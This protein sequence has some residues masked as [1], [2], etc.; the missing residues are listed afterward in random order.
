MFH[1]NYRKQGRR[2]VIMG[3]GRVK[4]V[5]DELQTWT[6]NERQLRVLSVDVVD[7]IALM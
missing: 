7:T 2:D 5:I 3:G 6:V 1:M 4:R